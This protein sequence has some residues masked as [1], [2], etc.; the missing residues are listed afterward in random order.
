MKKRNFIPIL[1]MLIS[2]FLLIV[3]TDCKT[4]QKCSNAPITLLVQA[5]QSDGIVFSWED[6]SEIKYY[7]IS[8]TCLNEPSL[9]SKYYDFKQSKGDKLQK[10]ITYDDFFMAGNLYSVSMQAD[11]RKNVLCGKKDFSEFTN[12]VYVVGTNK[13][14]P[15]VTTHL[16]STDAANVYYS[17]E[18]TP[19]ASSYKVLVIRDD[20]AELIKTSTNRLAIPRGDGVVIG[21]YPTNGG[22][23]GGPG[24]GGGHQGGGGTVIIIDDLNCIPSGKKPS[25]FPSYTVTATST[26]TSCLFLSQTFS[27]FPACNGYWIELTNPPATPCTGAIIARRYVSIPGGTT[28]GSF[29]INYTL[30]CVCPSYAYNIKITPCTYPN[31]VN[32]CASSQVVTCSNCTNWTP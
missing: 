25:I 29:T 28:A 22:E 16:D 2:C 9:G 30:R 19:W 4:S 3:L 27:S 24:G 14:I 31:G 8:M 1:A 6:D 23:T 32:R 7:R 12:K 15:V 5:R 10:L 11:Y 13:Q 21:I 20:N 18:S 17:W 26:S